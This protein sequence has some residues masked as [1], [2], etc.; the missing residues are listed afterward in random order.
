MRRMNLCLAVMSLLA[1]RAHTAN[2]QQYTITD[3]GALGSSF[4]RVKRLNNFG[5]VIGTSLANTGKHR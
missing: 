2:A 3:I 5:Q 4:S 1:G